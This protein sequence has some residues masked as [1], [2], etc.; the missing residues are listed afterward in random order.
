[1]GDVGSTYNLLVYVYGQKLRIRFAD[2][3]RGVI[4]DIEK[5]RSR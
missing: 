4:F 1:M 3:V 5:D 2:H